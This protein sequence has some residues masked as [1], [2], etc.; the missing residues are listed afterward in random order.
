M[1]SKNKLT[2]MG[3]FI[4]RLRDNGY[5]VDRLFT[6][7]ALTDPRSWTIVIDPLGA[8]I[9]CTCYQNNP[10][11][12]AVYFEVYDGGQFIDGKGYNIVTTSIEVFIEHLVKFGINRKS[13]HYPESRT[14]QNYHN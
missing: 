5:V 2:T 4:K 6:N 11:L 13:P 12:G 3:Y 7:Y 14:N 8:A 10:E 9:F 1:A